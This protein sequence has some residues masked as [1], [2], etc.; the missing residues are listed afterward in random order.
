MVS[1]RKRKMA[2]SSVKKN[3]RRTKDKQRNINVYSNPIIAKNWDKSLTLQ[4]NYKR[5]GLRAKLGHMAGG[6]EKKV[7][8]LTELRNK[9]KNKDKDDIVTIDKIE[10]TDDPSKIP[11]GEARIIRDPETNEVL[12]VIYGTMK[13]EDEESDEDKVD[14]SVIK[15]LEE[16][17]EQ[18]S[19]VKKERHLSDRESDWLKSLYE[20]YGDDYEKMKW[21]KK[22]NIYQQSAGDLK[23]RINKWK[24][25]NGL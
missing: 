2:R 7:E 10:H 12:K 24:K 11:E 1:V 21:D 13:A 14:N 16:Y 4:Q 3:T 17:A 5:L 8:S 18:H 20:K 19:K 22:L 23:R 25:G 9:K 15:Q 6:V